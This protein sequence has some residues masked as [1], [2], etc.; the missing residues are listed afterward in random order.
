MGQVVST[1]SG[2]NDAIKEPPPETLTAILVESVPMGVALPCTLYI[3]VAGR[4]VLFRSQGERLTPK[5]AL[6]LQ[7]KGAEVL[8]INNAAWGVFLDALEKLQLSEPITPESAALHLRHLIVAYGLELERVIREPKRPLFEKLEKLCDSLASV[9]RSNPAVGTRLLR[10]VEEPSMAFITHA[11]NCGIYA[12]V[13]GFK[14]GFSLDEMKQVTYAA[15]VHDIGKLLIPK[16]I[17]LKTG[18][19]TVEE[20]DLLQGHTRQ[21]AEMLQSMGSQP[22]AVLTAL[23]HHERM[24]GQ[25]YP[26]RLHGSQLHPFTRITAIVDAYDTLTSSRPTR[27][28]LSPAE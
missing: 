27:P 24:D 1:Q 9:I 20:K 10:K 4:F 2:E 12:A 11:V 18:S 25:G 8:Y 19:L 22:A 3:K 6:M 14:M 26:S 21:G 28:A 23:Q 7:E 17:L 13:I 5:R 15:L 16:K